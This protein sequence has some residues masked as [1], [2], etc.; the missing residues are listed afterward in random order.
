MSIEGDEK[1]SWRERW[2]AVC[3]PL[4][5]LASPVP[6]ADTDDADPAGKKDE[7][8]EQEP[9]QVEEVEY[10]EVRTPY[11]PESNNIATKLPVPLQVTPFNV[12]VVSAALI[13]D[14]HAI[15]MGDALRNVSGVNVQDQ[16]GVADYFLVRG[17]NQID[18]GLVLTDGATEPE[19]TYWN[20]YNV[21]GVEVLK[22][23]GGFLYGANPLASAVN[24]V[25]KQPLPGDFAVFGASVGSFDTYQASL[26]W[27][28]AN[29]DGRKSFRLNSTFIDSG[30]YRD[31]KPNRQFGI[32]PGFTLRWGESSSLNFN[33][34]YASSEFSPDSG[35]ALLGDSIPDVPRTN[36][37]QRPSDFSEQGISRFQIDYQTQLNDK[38]TL[39]NKTYFRSLDWQS[40]RTLIVGSFPLPPEFGGAQVVRGVT[41][42]DNDQDILGNQLEAIVKLGG[43]KITHSLLFGVEIQRWD[44]PYDFGVAPPCQPGVDPPFCLPT[45]SL[46]NPTEQAGQL[47]VQPYLVGDETRNAV[48]PYVIDQIKFSE[49][50]QL[51]IGARYDFIDTDVVYQFNAVAPGD[52]GY[53]RDDSDV[54]PMAGLVF[55]PSSSLTVYAN[56]ASSFSP[57]SSRVLGAATLE[58]EQSEQL[59]IGAKK[60]FLDGKLKTTFAVYRLDRSNIAIP[61][62]N[63]VTQQAGD[64]RSDGFE[65]ELAAEPLPRLRTFFSY[66]YTDAVLTRFSESIPGFGVFDRSGNRPA[67]VPEHL[68]NLWVS[69]SFKNGLGVGGGLRYVS[70][71]FIAEDNAFAIDSYLLLDAALYYDF[72][73]FRLKLNFRNLTDTEYETRGFGSA[74][75]IPADP[76]SVFATFEYRL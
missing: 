76:F 58:P 3:L 60:Q 42:L 25:R 71:Q 68:A 16:S 56:A 75:V 50:F 29:E 54:S 13:R 41:T 12:G 31:D 28:T 26:D 67:F 27:N 5:L 21:E 40:S 62:D 63:G 49:R 36:S 15:V 6:A 19:A 43:G 23:P 1:V 18:G 17:Y 64:Q 4:L 45:I 10:I 46:V 2:L 7:Q 11:A 14:Q 9:R 24:L 37:Y 38:V 70:D 74:S 52:T 51:L 66:A 44:N 61:D 48:A 34:E 32:N 72:D 35:I 22:G 8:A 20:L 33:L 55:T 69:R 59:E 30:G 53:T 39:R 65:L 57:I 73:A 47:V